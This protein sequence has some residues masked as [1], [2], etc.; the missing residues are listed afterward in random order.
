[1]SSSA[2][3]VLVHGTEG[4]DQVGPGVALAGGQRARAPGAEAG[5]GKMEGGVGRMQ[6]RRQRMFWSSD[7]SPAEDCQQRSS[8]ARWG[9]KGR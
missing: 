8:R 1:M 2:P 4:E 9:E 7:P 3:V 5:V 6:S